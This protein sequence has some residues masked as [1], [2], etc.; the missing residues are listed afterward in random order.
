MISYENDIEL[1]FCN[2]LNLIGLVYCK[3][4]LFIV[5]CCLLGSFDRVFPVVQQ[6]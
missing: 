2:D 1:I 6:R 4:T 3:T 5:I